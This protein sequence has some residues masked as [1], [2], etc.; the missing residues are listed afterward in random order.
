MIRGDA[1][2]AW[3]AATAVA[4][5]IAPQA[6]ETAHALDRRE[7][8]Y[9]SYLASVEQ[10]HRAARPL[11]IYHEGADQH[12]PHEQT[13]AAAEATVTA[14]RE[15]RSNF[16]RYTA[17]NVAL[18]TATRELDGALAGGLPPVL[19][20][21]EWTVEKQTEAFTRL[22][23]EYWQADR[24][25]DAAN[26]TTT[27]FLNLGDELTNLRDE[28]AAAEH[29]DLD[30]W[31]NTDR[32]DDRPT[33]HTPERLAEEALRRFAHDYPPETAG[34]PTVIDK[35]LEAT[36]LARVIDARTVS[37]PHPQHILREDPSRLDAIASDAQAI[38]DQPQSL[39]PQASA[40]LWSNISE[41]ADGVPDENYWQRDASDYVDSR[42]ADAC[43]TIEATA[44]QPAPAADGELSDAVKDAQRF[45]AMSFP[46]HPAAALQQAGT[47]PS[48]DLDRLSAARATRNAV[49]AAAQRAADQ[50][51]N[52]ADIPF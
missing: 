32:Q 44:R 42:L 22:A 15:A 33:I 49:N 17:E 1:P 4:H 36:N 3:A 8:A 38:A 25:T 27:D 52:E 11:S 19:A 20:Q 5:A 14:A 21:E 51:L 6:S 31:L 16:A 34:R 45:R 50:R 29:D 10:I 43:R 13:R 26:R 40:A 7:Q 12:P 30:D 24:P 41:V 47:T 23:Y 28:L 18:S 2:Q 46:Q 35:Y 48:V 39:T 9:V 37:F